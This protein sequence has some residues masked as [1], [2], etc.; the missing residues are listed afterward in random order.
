M[1]RATAVGCAHPDVGS[2]FSA[3]A[4]KAETSQDVEHV[5]GIFHV[6]ADGS[7]YLLLTV[8][9]VDGFG[10]TLGDVTG[11]IEFGT[12]A[13][14]PEGVQGNTLAGKCGSREVF[15][16]NGIAASDARKSCGLGK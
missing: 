3:I 13:T 9:S 12:L 1:P 14:I 6:V 8:W 10:S 15:G 16:Y 5:A 7:T 4:L 11:A 2:V